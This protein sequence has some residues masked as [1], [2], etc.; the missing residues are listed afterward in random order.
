MKISLQSELIVPM[1]F[2]HIFGI[3]NCYTCL[4]QH[5]DVMMKYEMKKKVIRILF[6]RGLGKNQEALLTHGD[7]V[8]KISDNFKS[9]GQTGSNIVAIANDKMGIYGL[10]F[11]PEVKEQGLSWEKK[12]TQIFIHQENARFK[13][14]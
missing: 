10:Q 12:S 1:T 14:L 11:H 3:I 2:W 6:C 4:I 7:V 9:V 5:I 13:S 8:T